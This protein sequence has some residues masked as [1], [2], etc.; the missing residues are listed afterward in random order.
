MRPSRSPAAPH[1][2][3]QTGPVGPPTPSLTTYQ[4]G[5]MPLLADATPPLRHHHH[6][7]HHRPVP[8]QPFDAQTQSTVPPPQPSEPPGAC[9]RP[10]PV[11]PLT[12]LTPPPPVPPATH[13]HP[14]ALE[15]VWLPETSTRLFFPSLKQTTH[16]TQQTKQD[17]GACNL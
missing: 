15:A 4:P 1:P 9:Q 11:R 16:N 12:R 3:Q 13:P 6:H 8:M 2:A 7:H 5:S 14:W 17:T 10:A